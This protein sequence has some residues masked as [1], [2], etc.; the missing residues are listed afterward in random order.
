M[1][2]KIQLSGFFEILGHP[3][4]DI[5]GLA[6]YE[7]VLA[8]VLTNVWTCMRVLQMLRAIDTRP[9]ELPPL[10]LQS[11]ALVVVWTV[12]KPPS[13]HL[14]SL[15]LRMHGECLCTAH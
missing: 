4:P 9:N 8:Y 3:C 13:S 10:I 15:Q 14:N 2:L 6:V 11:R 7:F 5:Q 1:N 12:S